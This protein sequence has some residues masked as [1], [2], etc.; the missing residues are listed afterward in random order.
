MVNLTLQSITRDC[1]GIVYFFFLD[2]SK[3]TVFALWYWCVVLCLPLSLEYSWTFKDF[4]RDMWFY[5]Y[6]VVCGH[7]TRVAER[8]VADHVTGVTIQWVSCEWLTHVGSLE[9]SSC[10][11]IV[12]DTACQFHETECLLLAS[13]RSITFFVSACTCCHLWCVVHICAQ[14]SVNF[15]NKILGKTIVNRT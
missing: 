9:S 10:W 6:T 5:H 7:A 2:Y 11:C 4:Y 8:L 12:S 13:Q 15:Q 1:N 3:V 14:Y